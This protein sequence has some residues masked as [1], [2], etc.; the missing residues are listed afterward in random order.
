MFKLLEPRFGKAPR[1]PLK[2]LKLFFTIRHLTF[3]L[4]IG[5]PADLIEAIVEIDQIVEIDHADAS[6]ASVPGA[7]RALDLLAASKKEAVTPSM[8]T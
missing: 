7:L 6:S 4:S 1:V 5:G 3:G 8:S 2:Y